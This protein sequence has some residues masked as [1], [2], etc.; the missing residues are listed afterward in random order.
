MSHLHSP[1]FWLAA[2]SALALGC[3]NPDRWGP[4]AER[5]AEVVHRYIGAAAPIELLGEPTQTSEG[6]VEIRYRTETGFNIPEE[7]A[8]S[9]RFEVGEA[10]RL[11][12]LAASVDGGMLTEPEVAAIRDALASER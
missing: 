12:L 8:A 3:E 7:G 2:V 10:G 4:V 1:V 5:C 6:S 11:S 9:C